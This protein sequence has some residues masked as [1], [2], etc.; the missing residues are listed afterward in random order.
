MAKNKQ[1]LRELLDKLNRL[2]DTLPTKETANLAEGIIGKKYEELHNQLKDDVSLEYLNKIHEKLSNFKKDYDLE[3]V[4]EMFER[5]QGEIVSAKEE[6][7]FELNNVSEDGKAKRNELSGLLESTKNDL[8]ELTGNQIKNILTKIGTLETEVFS[9][10]GIGTLQTLAKDL[11]Q[12]TSTIDKSFAQF[13]KSFSW[14]RDNCDRVLGLLKNKV[15][16]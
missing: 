4:Y 6:I 2:G 8:T 9:D 16:E 14:A 11:D 12:R 10:K 7:A 3:P 1:K 15:L 5:L 13:D